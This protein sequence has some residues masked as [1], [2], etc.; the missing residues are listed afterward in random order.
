L[1][2]SL[3]QY[4]FDHVLEPLIGKNKCLL[5][6]DCW[7]AQGAGEIYSKLVNIKRLEIPKK[8]TSM[9][10]P[11]DVYFN[12]QYKLIAR[13]MYDYVRLHDIDINLAQRNNII[14]MNSLIYNQLSSKLFTRMIQYAWFQS[15]YLKTDPGPFKNVKEICFTF[16]HY[17]CNVNNCNETTFICCSWCEN[18]LCFNH[19]FLDYHIH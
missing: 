4:W 8:T 14:K 16:E 6:S 11:L 10:Q 5:L 1:T 17:L 3:V 12:R 18:S 19:F 2:T 15:G 7:G 13:K 9:I